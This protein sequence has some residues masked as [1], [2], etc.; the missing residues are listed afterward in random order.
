M[1]AVSFSSSRTEQTISPERD[2]RQEL[3]INVNKPSYA[4]FLADAEIDRV[5]VGNSASPSSKLRRD[6]CYDDLRDALLARFVSI[7]ITLIAVLSRTW[8]CHCGRCTSDSSIAILHTPFRGL[9]TNG[10]GRAGLSCSKGAAPVTT[11][12]CQQ[13]GRDRRLGG[14]GDRSTWPY[15]PFRVRNVPGADERR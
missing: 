5:L 15:P 12:R 3:W 2:G 10:C 7:F 4:R 6:R 9:A 14:V 1:L 11:N 13:A 8:R